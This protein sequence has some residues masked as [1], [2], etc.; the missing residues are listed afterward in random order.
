MTRLFDE[1]IARHVKYLNGAWN[2][3]TDPERKGEENKYFEDLPAKDKITVP[4]VWNTEKDLLKYEGLAWYQKKFYFEGGTLRLVFGAVLTEAKV[5]L[6]GKYLGYHYGGFSQFDFIVNGVEAGEH[7][8]TLSVDN[9]FDLQSIP[10]K[11]VDWYHYGGI[12]R[13]VTAEK[14]CGIVSLFNRF[15][16]ELSDSLEKANGSFFVEVYN[17]ENTEITDNIKISLDGE[18]VCESSVTLGAYE[19]K[20]IKFSEISLADI[21]LWNIDAPNLYDV[22]ISTSTDDLYDRIGLRKVSVEKGMVAINGKPVEIRGVNRHEEH[23]DWGFAFPQGLMRRDLDIIVD[24]LGCNSIRGSHYPNSKEFVDMLDERGV[25]FWSEIPVWGVGFSQAALGDPIVV[26]RGLEMHREMVKYY[27]N[28][29]CII[30][31][32][33]H[34]EIKCDTPEG[35]EMSRLYYNYLKENGG[36][37]LVTYAANRPMID[38]CFEF[39]DIISANL[40][41]GWYG[42]GLS[43]WD[44]FASD[45][46][47][48]REELGFSAKP[49]IMSEFGAAALYGYHTFDNVHWTEEYQ[50]NLMEH[51][52]ELFHRDD[53][54]CGFFVWQFCDMR[55]C[56]EAGINRARGFN[57]KGIVNEYRKPKAA[58]YKVRELYARYKAEENK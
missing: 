14:L 1:H 35:Y 50:A 13:D 34:N 32:G 20:E 46:R 12:I 37:R 55:T 8:L 29:P 24:D 43:D 2:F 27:Y 52:I 30:F 19:K 38:R 39:C 3:M 15:E 36:N 11:W 4:G 57:N 33:M 7:T 6:D 5:W 18:T 31:W 9:L 54:F 53:M 49:V 17:A 21:K 58:Y 51:A 16:Y 10:Q 42:G 56:L 28:H 44:K 45:F 47:K 40:Y 25:I 22:K 41:F 48:R 26:E 23:P